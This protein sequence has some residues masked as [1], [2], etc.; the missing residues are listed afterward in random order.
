MWFWALIASAI[1]T[2]FFLIITLAQIEA[3]TKSKSRWLV[4]TLC[5]LAVVAGLIILKPK[6]NM[7]PIQYMPAPLPAPENVNKPK[8][9][10]I[11]KSASKS[12]GSA[13]GL[14]AG[15]KPQGVTGKT[16]GVQGQA[17]G[18][19][20]KAQGEPGAKGTSGQNQGAPSIQDQLS[21]SLQK[22]SDSDGKIEYRDPVLEEILEL[23][24]QAEENSKET[25]I[26]EPPVEQNFRD[27]GSFVDGSQQMKNPNPGEPVVQ[28]GKD[29]FSEG[30]TEHQITDN[31][32]KHEQPVQNQQVVKAKVL[33]SSLNVR[34]KGALGGLIIGSL[35]G[36]DIVE[37]IN[38]PETGEW[39]NIKLNSGLKGWVMK[40]YLEILP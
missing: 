2:A 17:K 6:A 4:L 7:E 15:E 20:E 35:N 21:K 38:Q 24:R 13:G 16:Q 29:L 9:D 26:E 11:K 40:K 18:A 32:K 19:P 3:G 37:V 5:S 22:K 34:D 30:Q 8:D 28:Q 25:A 39:S 14:T 31:K 27:A 23:K 10:A 36:G 33:V 1:F 12:S